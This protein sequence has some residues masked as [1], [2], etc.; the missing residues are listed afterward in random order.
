M[1]LIVDDVAEVIAI[2]AVL[3]NPAVLS[4]RRC[5]LDG[6]CRLSMMLL[7]FRLAL[8]DHSIGHQ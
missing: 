5:R 4:Y 1:P 2:A 6:G 3:L 7:H 8:P